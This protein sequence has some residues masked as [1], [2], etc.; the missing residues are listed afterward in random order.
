M[1]ARESWKT[2][3]VSAMPELEDDP[4]NDQNRRKSI[5]ESRLP[6]EEEGVGQGA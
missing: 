3:T 6:A 2:S 5:Q 4:W 1:T